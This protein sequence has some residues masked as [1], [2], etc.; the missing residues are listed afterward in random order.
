L[1][2][3]TVQICSDRTVQI[4]SGYRESGFRDVWCRGSL[5][6]RFRDRRFPD[7]VL[8]FGAFPDFDDCC[9]VSQQTDGWDLSS[10][11]RDMKC[12]GPLVSKIREMPNPEKPMNSLIGTFPESFD[13]CHVSLKD[14]RLRLRRGFHWNETRSPVLRFRDVPNPDLPMALSSSGIF[15]SR[16]NCATCPREMD[17]PDASSGYR[18]LRCS[19]DT[20]CLSRGN[21]ECR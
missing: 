10:Q 18:D 13:L 16:R 14:G 2:F 4:L 21:A 19:V 8:P 7:G 11:F 3:S 9:H 15:P 5:P 1:D 20:M 12:P 17:G 6:P